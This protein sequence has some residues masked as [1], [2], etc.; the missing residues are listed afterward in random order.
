[1]LEFQQLLTFFKACSS[2]DP[3]PIR[4]AF[5]LDNT[6]Q[7]DMNLFLRDHSYSKSTLLA[8]NIF[9]LKHVVNNV[10]LFVVVT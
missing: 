7:I 9:G 3:I 4:L 8:L 10:V 6:T 5:G 1:M 2:V